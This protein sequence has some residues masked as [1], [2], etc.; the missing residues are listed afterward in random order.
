MKSYFWFVRQMHG[1]G[2]D[3]VVYKVSVGSSMR[4][5]AK[6]ALVQEYAKDCGM[7]LERVSDSSDMAISNLAK[8]LFKDSSLANLYLRRANLT[9]SQ[10][11]KII[12]DDSFEKFEK[13]VT[14]SHSHALLLSLI[15]PSSF[16]HQKQ[17]HSNTICQPYRRKNLSQSGGNEITNVL[18]KAG[19][20]LALFLLSGYLEHLERY[21]Y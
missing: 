2:V 3:D 4:E 5:Q 15:S 10:L 13:S 9:I 17:S 20:I 18:I 8:S 12:I 11:Y 1:F 7:Y 16:Y 19:F 14:F 21:T 6:L